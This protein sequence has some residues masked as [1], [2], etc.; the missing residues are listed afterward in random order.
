MYVISCM[1]CIS[2]FF[3][4][5]SIY[6]LVYSY[7][8]FVIPYNIKSDWLGQTVFADFCGLPLFASPLAVATAR[9]GK[10]FIVLP[11]RAADNNRPTALPDSLGR[12]RQGEALWWLPTTRKCCFYNGF[13]WFSDICSRLT[14]VAHP[15]AVAMAR[16]RTFSLCSPAVLPTTTGLLLCPTRWDV[17]GEQGLCGGCPQRESVV[18]PMVFYGFPITVVG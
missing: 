3:L 13:L 1:S 9:Q 12:V 16:H 11:G 6:S 14:L 8:P 15:L 10:F 18:F 4:C 17:A 2:M 7:I 5:V